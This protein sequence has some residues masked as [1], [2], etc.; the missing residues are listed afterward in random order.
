MTPELQDAIGK[1][2]ASALLLINAIIIVASPTI[3]SWIGHK[4]A[5]LKLSLGDKRFTLLSAL[6]DAVV[7][8]VEQTGLDKVGA[9]KLQEALQKLAGAAQEHGIPVTDQM[10]KTVIEA[11]VH[12]LPFEARSLL[13]RHLQ[14]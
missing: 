11:A 7:R 8:E 10:L 2:L 1:F 13:N 6:A 12:D 5:D 14:N 4:K 3:I 9:Q